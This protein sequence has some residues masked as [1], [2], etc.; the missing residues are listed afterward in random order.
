MNTQNTMEK[1][2][3]YAEELTMKE[4]LGELTPE[5]KEI[6]TSKA[7]ASHKGWLAGKAEKG[8][9]YG[10]TTNDDP[11]AGPLTNCNMV[12]WDELDQETRQANVANAEAVIKLMQ[13]ELGARFVSF[14]DLVRKLAVGIHDEWC[15][16]RLAKGWK[17]GPVTDKANKVHR[18]LLPFEDLLADPA[19]AGD[20]DYDVNT[21]KEF[22]ISL[23]TEADIFPAVSI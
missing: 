11:A 14:T 12:A 22:L 10:P 8:Y 17:W 18:D 3:R 5:L 13:T 1:A 23:I 7:Q 21:A 6:A 4:A 2:L 15:R 19:L 9:V 20:C 16:D